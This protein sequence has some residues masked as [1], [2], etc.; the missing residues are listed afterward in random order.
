MMIRFF[1]IAAFIGFFANPSF[2]YD[3]DYIGEME[4]HEAIFEDTLVHLARNNNLGF[5][6]IRAANPDLDPWIPGA[7]EDIILPKQHLL[8]DAAREGIVINLP[9]MRLYYF[10]PDLEEPVTYS[11][12]IGR[13][14]LK[15]PTGETTIT[16]KKEGPTWRPT[17]RMRKEDPALPEVVEPGPDN[18]LGTHALYLGWPLY[19]I[20]GTN[21]PF[22]IG[23]RVSSGCIRLYPEGISDLFDRVKPGTKVNVVDQAVKIGWID[24]KMYVE[25]HPTQ[26]QTLEVEEVGLLKSYQISAE[27]M[28]R[29]MAKAGAYKDHINWAA[30]QDAVQKHNGYPV[31]ILDKDRKPRRRARKA[32]QDFES[33][34]KDEPSEEQE[35]S[36]DKKS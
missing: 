29:I 23:R 32:K 8:P 18:P 25:V 24:D 17:E 9:E 20:H 12:G 30:L 19:A 2:A 27:D 4:V 5:V 22:G 11:I 15:T 31:A 21:R 26:E 36:E 34:L 10:D 7:G 3:K 13:E 16:W 6:E 35:V 28:K 33:V 1:Y 14:G